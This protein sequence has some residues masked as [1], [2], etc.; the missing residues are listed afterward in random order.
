VGLVGG[1]DGVGGVEL[2]GDPEGFEIGEGSA[3]GEMAE[4]LRPA[5]HL[6]ERVDSFKLHGGAGAAAVERVVVGVDGHRHRVGRARDGMRGL[7]HLAGVERMEV[8]IVVVHP[9]GGLGEDRCSVLTQSWSWARRKVRK[10]CVEF[11]LR[12]AETLQEFV[13]LRVGS[14]HRVRK[15]NFAA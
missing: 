11:R 8:G 5:E 2:A 14:R 1:G 4:M 9:L 12:L 10:A 6:G 13:Q 7:E 15:P 3:A